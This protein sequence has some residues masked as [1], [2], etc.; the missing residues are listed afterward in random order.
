MTADREIEVITSEH[1]ILSH[2]LRRKVY[3]DQ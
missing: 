3:V 2:A 1:L